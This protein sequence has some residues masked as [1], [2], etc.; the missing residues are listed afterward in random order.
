MT[1]LVT[2]CLEG[3]PGDGE[4]R[5]LARPLP[6][7]IEVVLEGTA[8][9]LRRY[10]R[11][12]KSA[13][14]VLVLLAV[15]LRKFRADQGLSQEKAAHLIGCSVPTYRLLEH[16]W[17]REGRCADPKLST[18]M[19]ALSAIGVDALWVAALQEFA[20][21]SNENGPRMLS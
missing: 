1:S 21:H 12:K 17:S 15:Q 7:A 5:D 6:S 14:R 9:G 10:E 19:N 16:P 4:S 8:A 3:S 18:I 20:G 11:R 2:V 13:F